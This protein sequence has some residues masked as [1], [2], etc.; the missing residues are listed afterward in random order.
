MKK[1]LIYFFLFLLN[2]NFAQS[3]STSFMWSSVGANVSADY[4]FKYKK[5]EPFI[6]MMYHINTPVN[7]RLSHSYKHRFYNR[8]FTDGLGAVLGLSVPIRITDSDLGLHFIF[9]NQI[10]NMHNRRLIAIISGTGTNQTIDYIYTFSPSK[11]WIV[12][13]YIG[14]GASVKMHKSVYLNVSYAAGLANY[15]VKNQF[16][17]NQFFRDSE[18]GTNLKLALSYQLK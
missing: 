18:I 11:M 1:T 6:G 15:M 4:S 17:G 10:S 14:L 5:I 2:K 7:D 13:N 12:E 8:T 16:T 3:V 9:I